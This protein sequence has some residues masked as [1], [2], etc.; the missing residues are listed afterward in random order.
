[1]QGTTVKKLPL[2]TKHAAYLAS[3]VFSFELMATDEEPDE[4]DPN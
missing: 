2:T 1:L 4:D 3:S